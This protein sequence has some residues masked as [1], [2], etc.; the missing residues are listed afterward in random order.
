MGTPSITH[1]T[2]SAHA[3][4][5]IAVLLL[6]SLTAPAQ[7]PSISALTVPL[8][9]P[10]AVVFDA[11]GNLYFAETGNHVIRKV[12]TAGNITAIAGTGVQGFSGDAGPATAA[13][14]DSPQGLALDNANGTANNLYLADTHNHR[15]RKINLTT[16]NITTI[17]G[18][19]PGFS[20]DNASA[21]S[22]QLNLPTALA[23]DTTGNLYIADTGNHRIR[24]ISAA[25]II[26]TIAGTGTQGFS[27]DNALAIT[28]AIDSPTGLA[29]DSKNNLYLTD[30]H[31]HRIRKITAAR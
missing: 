11:A 28:A 25:G 3:P 23:V 26:T 20:G 22:A 4:L 6:L 1:P 10:S 27:G 21:T 29:L 5:R 2:R 30:T 31:N 18:T 12:D 13:T 8:I 7:T 14:I 24:K 16:G 15:I 19:T 9:L 17:A